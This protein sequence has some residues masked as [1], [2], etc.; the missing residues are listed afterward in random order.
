MIPASNKFHGR[1]PCSPRFT[2]QTLRGRTL[3]GRYKLGQ[4][5]G[6]GGA[7]EVYAATDLQ[8]GREVAVKVMS[9][10]GCTCPECQVE[11][12]CEDFQGSEREPP[13]GRIARFAAEA[14]LGAR[15][16]DP[17][18][19]QV[20]DSGVARIDGAPRPYLVMP[21]VR[22]RSLRT[23][24]LEGAIPW[25]HV[26]AYGRQLL[27]GLSAIHEQGV[28][29]G[30]LKPDNCMICECSGR[31]P[32]IRIIDLGEAV[33]VRMSSA[34]PLCTPAYCAP[35]RILGQ[36][37][38]VQV[39]LY[40]VGV[41]LY[42]M[43]CRRPPFVGTDEQVLRGHL[44]EEPRSLREAA[45][46]ASIPRSLERLVLAALSKDPQ[47]RVASASSF[48]LALE[49][50]CPEKRRSFVGEQWQR[51]RIA[52][53][54]TTPLGS[55]GFPGL[56]CSPRHAGSVQAQASLAAWTRFEYARAQQ[57]ASVA[58]SLNRAWSPLWLLMSLTPED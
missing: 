26:A 51:D 2:A 12:P 46:N 30:D 38:S 34:R 52:L 5:L 47:C 19:V 25:R 17:H 33:S 57:E 8:L 3:G 53:S 58:V 54:G 41:I 4:Q 11:D 39:D 22:G 31:E 14:K 35:E 43:L 44:E 15:I 27:A 37:I 45:P 36:E 21:W 20:F 10:D 50:A 28:L 18:V 55:A 23:R 13:C 42:E 1:G 48:E 24:I 6:R 9:N 16:D 32:Y 40:A 29:H 56:S 7:A 49:L